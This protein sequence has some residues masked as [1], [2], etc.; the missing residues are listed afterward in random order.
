M[1]MSKDTSKA[2]FII[3]AALAL[4]FVLLLYANHIRPH[5]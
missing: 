4:L 1:A 3:V 5:P 2:I